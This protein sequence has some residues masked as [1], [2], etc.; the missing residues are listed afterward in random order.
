MASLSRAADECC[1]AAIVPE[2]LD[3]LLAGLEAAAPSPAGGTAAAVVAA[4]AASLVVMVARESPGWPAGTETA[5]RATQLRD[6][7]VAL[8]AEDVRA[9]AAVLAASRADD[10]GAFAAALVRASEVPLEIAER[11]ADV[12]EIATRAAV[13]GKRPMRPDAEV[14]AILAA[15][16]TR[17]A[18]LLVRVNVAA[19]P[20]S[21]ANETA[22]RLLAAAEAAEDRTAS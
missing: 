15:A 20:T 3:E 13:E 18:A 7:L 1:H 17:A 4:M 12:A 9:F 5:T 22:A 14:A 2:T 19:L 21:G 10:S 8:G 16:A 6:R 11:A